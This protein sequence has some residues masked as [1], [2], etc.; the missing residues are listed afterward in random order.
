KVFEWDLKAEDAMIGF[1]L[2]LFVGWFLITGKSQSQELVLG[3]SP[4]WS[5]ILLNF[6]KIAVILELFTLFEE[7]Q[8]LEAFATLFFLV[9]G[10]FDLTLLL[11]RRAKIDYTDLILN[12]FQ[13]ILAMFAGTFQTIKWLLLIGVFAV[14]D[15]LNLGLGTW[16]L[17]LFAVA[18][19]FVTFSE[20]IFRTTLASGIIESRVEEGKAII[21]K[22][23]EEIHQFEGE[24]FQIFEIQNPIE[25]R[26]RESITKLSPGSQLLRLPFSSDL[27]E[28][29][30]IF[31]TQIELKRGSEDSVK[32]AFFVSSRTHKGGQSLNLRSG[33][34]H[35]IEKQEWDR[36]RPHLNLRDKTEIAAELGF[37]N[38]KPIDEFF[39]HSIQAAIL[40]Q[41]HVQNRLR[42]VPAPTTA[43][44]ILATVQNE[45]LLLPKEFIETKCI[46]DGAQI[47]IIP[48]KDEYLFYGRIKKR[49]ESP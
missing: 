15:R 20:S 1:L 2:I 39:Q 34:I 4:F 36:I 9:A 16:A 33:G 12:P 7:L 43:K 28:L 13:L 41:E 32:P 24:D 25:L 46:E 27:E 21:P 37:E 29:S 8:F 26:R 35:R 40:A 42:G 49:S 31:L 3:L 19:A 48:G 14:L 44:P 23:F 17:I 5:S 30:G 10:F 18:V 11:T 47:E 45:A 22:I 6:W 38:S